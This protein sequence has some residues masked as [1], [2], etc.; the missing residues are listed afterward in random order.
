[1]HRAGSPGVVVAGRLFASE[2]KAM[3]R[4]VRLP[5]FG[6]GEDFDAGP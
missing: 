3:A 1:M 5:A 6:A 2:A 4:D